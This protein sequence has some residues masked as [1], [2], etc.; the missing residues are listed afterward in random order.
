MG[1]ADIGWQLNIT[2]VPEPK[3]LG[4]DVRDRLAG[5]RCR[6]KMPVEST[7]LKKLSVIQFPQNPQTSSVVIHL[8][9]PRIYSVGQKGQLVL[10]FQQLL[11]FC[12]HCLIEA[13]HDKAPSLVI[14]P[15]FLQCH[16][17]VC[18]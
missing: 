12:D 13:K 18:S 9:R 1:L 17:T 3:H 4:A 7:C 2:A 10:P 6:A 16:L 15:D 14:M 11:H 8:K 5:L